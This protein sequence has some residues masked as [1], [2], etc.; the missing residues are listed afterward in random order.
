M[1]NAE[2]AVVNNGA[3]ADIDR[4]GPTLFE[5]CVMGIVVQQKFI[6]CTLM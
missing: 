6:A 2:V 3:C 4:S 1:G 5:F